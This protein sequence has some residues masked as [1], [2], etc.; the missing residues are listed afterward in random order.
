MVVVCISLLGKTL[1]SVVA[2]KNSLCWVFWG[3]LGVVEE[4]MGR[5]E[6]VGEVIVVADVVLRCVFCFLL[7]VG[8]SLFLFLLGFGEFEVFDRPVDL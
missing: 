8:S 5:V 6:I 4:S 7:A 1:E 3:M 2:L